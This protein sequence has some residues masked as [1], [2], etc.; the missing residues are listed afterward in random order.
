LTWKRDNTARLYPTWINQKN[1]DRLVIEQSE[2]ELEYSEQH[3]CDLCQS[4]GKTLDCCECCEI[5]VYCDEYGECD[6]V[7]FAESESE[8]IER[9][10][11]F[12]KDYPNGWFEFAVKPKKEGFVFR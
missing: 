10:K 2:T 8:A 11:E 4:C 5:W 6:S 7:A 9:A 3:A 12:M 1:K